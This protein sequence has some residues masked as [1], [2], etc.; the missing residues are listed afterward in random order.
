M[1]AV[2]WRSAPARGAPPRAPDRA[3]RRHRSGDLPADRWPCC[4]FGSSTESGVARRLTVERGFGFRNA[5][6]RWFGAADANMRIDDLAALQPIGDQ[7]GSHREVAGAAVEFVE[8]EFC[9]A[10][11]HRQPHLGEQFILG[12]SGRHD[13][14][15]IIRRLDLACAARAFGDHGGVERG[16]GQAPFRGRIGMGE[17]AAKGAAHADR[18]M[19]DM[20]RD[21]CEQLAERAV[22]RPAYEKPRGAR[23]RRCS[24]PCRRLKSC[25]DLRP[26]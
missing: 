10:R 26:R 25:R 7:R 6:W 2:M 1:C 14:V 15:E 24:A 18:I 22:R 19:R 3:D 17:A 9:I 8:A 12:Q 23:R 11:Q 16:G 20:A 4:C 5:A 21:E 13:A